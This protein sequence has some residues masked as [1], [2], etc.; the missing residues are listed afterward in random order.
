MC[1]T[2]F[3]LDD[4]V[5]CAVEDPDDGY[6]SYLKSVVVADNVTNLTFAP[7]PLLSV[8]IEARPALGEGG[9]ALVDALSNKVILAVGTSDYDDYYP[10][11][12][13]EYQAPRFFQEF[14]HHPLYSLTTLIK[15]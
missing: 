8:K 1:G 3:K 7:D 9:F 13:F 2:C 12:V 15:D 6:R 14:M 5:F 4:I 11:F 10:C